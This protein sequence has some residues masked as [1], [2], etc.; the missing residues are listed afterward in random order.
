MHSIFTCKPKRFYRFTI[1]KA[2][3]YIQRLCTRWLV[4]GSTHHTASAAPSQQ[5]GGHLLSRWYCDPYLKF[6][7]RDIP[8]RRKDVLRS[9]REIIWNV[10][11]LVRLLHDDDLSLNNRIPICNP[12]GHLDQIEVCTIILE[13]SNMHSYV[14][15][16]PEYRLMDLVSIICRPP[17]SCSPPGL[18][19]HRTSSASY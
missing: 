10:F 6:Q 18:H 15:S 11:S 1:S 3:R 13:G 4:R 2:L 9:V 5:L 16:M 17:L 14:S 8:T 19:G 12:E 7:L